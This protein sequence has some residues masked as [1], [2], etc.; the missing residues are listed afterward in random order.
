MDEAAML[1]KRSLELAK[2]LSAAAKAQGYTV[3]EVYIAALWMAAVLGAA[4]DLDEDIIV[5]G[6]R[7]SYSD[8]AGHK[9]RSR[10]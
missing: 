9:E 8:V 5:E 6:I 10:S 3:A 1:S 2:A 4:M 7:A